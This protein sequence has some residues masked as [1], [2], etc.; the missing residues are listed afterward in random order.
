VGLRPFLFLFEFVLGGFNSSVCFFAK[1]KKKKKEKRKE[2]KRK[3]KKR[4][5]LHKS[6][7]TFFFLSLWP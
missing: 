2:M 5:R 6:K 7:M 4:K 3:E 1:K